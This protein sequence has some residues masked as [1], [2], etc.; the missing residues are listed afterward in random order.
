MV[1][2]H[3]ID[4]IGAVTAHHTCLGEILLNGLGTTTQ[5]IRQELALI[6]VIYLHIVILRLHIVERVG[7]DGELQRAVVVIEVYQRRIGHRTLTH[8]HLILQHLQLL[9]LVAVGGV[10]GQHSIRYGHNEDNTP[11]SLHQNGY[12][13][14]LLHRHIEQCE[15]GV[16][17]RYNQNLHHYPGNIFGIG[18]AD[19]LLIHIHQHLAD[20]HNS[21]SYDIEGDCHIELHHA[22]HSKPRCVG[23]WSI[24]RHKEDRKCQ[25]EHNRSKQVAFIQQKLGNFPVF[26][27]ICH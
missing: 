17:D 2:F 8:R 1:D 6:L 16:E 10:E 23:K 26:V 19:V 12:L 27:Y 24:N 13:I 4:H 20:K 18:K 9:G 3:H 14:N 21:Q 11:Q 22:S 15:V 25:N 7:V 5:H